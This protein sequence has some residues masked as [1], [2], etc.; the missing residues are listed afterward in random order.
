MGENAYFE[1]GK[2]VFSLDPSG[3]LR[4]PEISPKIGKVNRKREGN[5]LSA[6]ERI[7]KIMDVPVADPG[8]EEIRDLG[9]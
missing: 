4:R 6:Q 5:P 3:P 8:F 2:T 7:E 1:R 9:A